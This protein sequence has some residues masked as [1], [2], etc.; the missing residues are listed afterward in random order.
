MR[1][2]PDIFIEARTLYKMQINALEFL[3]Q[4]SFHI[5]GKSDITLNHISDIAKGLPYLTDLEA[6]LDTSQPHPIQF[7][8]SGLA[9][10][11]T[12]KVK[13]NFQKDGFEGL[14]LR[15]RPLSSIQRLTIK[16]ASNCKITFKP[17][18]LTDLLRFSF[19]ITE[20]L[21]KSDQ[22]TFNLQEL[23]KYEQNEANRSWKQQSQR[24]R[25]KI[26]Y[27]F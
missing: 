6:I 18:I 2:K 26:R 20:L 16:A 23:K 5:K 14:C 27:Y 4:F 7:N 10:I 12:L 3:Q 11:K 9:R 15:I 21:I 22:Q 8:L 1:K 25:K 24:N 19:N 13:L 17:T